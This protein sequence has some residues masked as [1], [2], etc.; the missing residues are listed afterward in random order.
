MRSA[1]QFILHVLFLLAPPNRQLYV[2]L[3]RSPAVRVI[4]VLSEMFKVHATSKLCAMYEF[5][6][7]RQGRLITAMPLL[8][9][10][11]AD[12]GSLITTYISGYVTMRTEE[13][14]HWRNYWKDIEGTVLLALLLCGRRFVHQ[15]IHIRLRIHDNGERKS[16]D[17]LLEGNHWRRHWLRTNLHRT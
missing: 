12:E 8:P 10:C 15:N 9:N 2:E 16:L 17:K 11:F 4:R 5:F 3:T 13:G 14:N 1:H 7:Y 6:L